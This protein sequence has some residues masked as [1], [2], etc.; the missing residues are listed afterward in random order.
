MEACQRE[1]VSE[2]SPVA[3]KELKYTCILD[4][5][6]MS[7]LCTLAS[8]SWGGAGEASAGATRLICREKA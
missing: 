5:R 7:S 1:R 8:A 6:L 2:C 3:T 4:S